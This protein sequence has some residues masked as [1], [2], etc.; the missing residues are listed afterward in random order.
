LISPFRVIAQIWL[1]FFPKSLQMISKPSSNV[2]S[3]GTKATHDD[4]VR[5]LRRGVCNTLVPYWE[6]IYR[7][8]GL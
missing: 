6:E 8:S 1:A 2:R 7:V 4:V 5:G 3:C